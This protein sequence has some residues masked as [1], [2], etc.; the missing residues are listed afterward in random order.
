MIRKGASEE[1]GLKQTAEG[2]EGMR[3]ARI[4]GREFWTEKIR[5]N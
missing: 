5:Q 3:H 2:R 4:K 1:V